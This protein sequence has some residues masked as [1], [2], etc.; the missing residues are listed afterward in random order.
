M[1]QHRHLEG[2]QV[3]SMKTALPT[4]FCQNA[5]PETLWSKQLDAVVL[6]AALCSLPVVDF[7]QHQIFQI[8]QFVV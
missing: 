7:S 8:Q 5:Q 4:T 1:C 3:T 6:I 2:P